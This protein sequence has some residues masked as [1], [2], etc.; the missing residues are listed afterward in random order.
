MDQTERFLSRMFQI[1]TN[2]INSRGHLENM[3]TLEKWRKDGVILM[4]M[5]EVAQKECVVDR[6]P[7]RV[8]KT[9]GYIFSETLAETTEEQ[10]LLTRIERILFPEG[11]KTQNERNDVEIVFNAKKYGSIL[12]TAD[13]GSKS[14]PGGI[15]GHKE[16]LAGLGIQVMSDEEAVQHVRGFIAARDRQATWKHE[17]FGM[18]LPDWVG[19][20]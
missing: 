1:D 7:K 16:E 17:R 9:L 10:E 8:E 13:G 4:E 14:Q 3:N 6:N 11:A 2:R 12:V 20:D 18:P 5:S 15:L 19:K